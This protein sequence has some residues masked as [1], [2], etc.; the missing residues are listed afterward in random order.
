MMLEYLIPQASSFAHDID[1]LFMVILLTV[2]FWFFV[3]QGVLFYFIFRFRRK[4]GV[5]SLYVAGEDK[6]EKNWVR[7]P[8]FLVIICDIGLIAGTI[9]VWITVKQALPPAEEKVRIIGQQW[10]WTF[11]HAGPDGQLDTDDDITVVDEL[12]VKADTVYHFELLS[13]DVIHSFS[14]PVFRLKQDAVPGRVITGW[15]KPT[16]TGQFDIQ[17]AEMCGLGHGVMGARLRIETKEEHAQWMSE[18]AA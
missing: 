4:D 7:I 3:A 12:H 14:V 17:C 16:K 9:L 18:Q 13:K 15:F 2:G 11:V 8:H 5:R 1:W 6:A 10:A